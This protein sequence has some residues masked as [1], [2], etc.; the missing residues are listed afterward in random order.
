MTDLKWCVEYLKTVNGIKGSIGIDGFEELRALMNITMPE[1]LS[2][3]FYVRQD[4]VLQLELSKKTIVAAEDLSF[5]K[6]KVCLFKG[7]ITTIKADAIVNACNSKMLGCFVPLHYCIDNAIHTFAGLEMRRDLM[8]VMRAQGH[9][10]PNG[11]CKVT[12]GY[13]LPAKYVLHTV[14]PIYSHTNQDIV[15]LKNCYQNCLRKADEMALKTLVFCSLS[16]GVFGYPIEE[17]SR[18]A[19]LTV[20][21]Y[22]EDENKH[23]ERVVFNLFSEKD[24]DTYNRKIEEIYR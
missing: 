15:D 11:R 6:D 2:D 17:A 12:E 9:D 3:E 1:D 21:N 22:L 24:Y 5:V 19:I 13:N 14:G 4:A 23:I 18:I 20:K 8:I 16:T 10:E 7:D